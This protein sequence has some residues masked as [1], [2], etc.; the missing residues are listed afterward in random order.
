M[1]PRKRDLPDPLADLG[2]LRLAVEAE[3]AGLRVEDPVAVGGERL[4]QL[5]RALHAE[6]PVDDRE[7]EDVETAGGR[8]RLR[9]IGACVAQEPYLATNHG[10]RRLARTLRNQWT[11][12]G[13][14]EPAG[15]S[16]AS[17]LFANT[18][19]SEIGPAPYTPS[20]RSNG[21]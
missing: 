10:A 3:E 12:P 21:M 14:R 17:S 15:C 13:W 1:L 18:R 5:L 8:K 4:Q 6:A 11:R 20:Q 2:D 16:P 19:S 9:G 7:A